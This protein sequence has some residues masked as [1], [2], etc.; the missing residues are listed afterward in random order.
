MVRIKNIEDLLAE[1]AVRKAATCYS[2]GVG[3]K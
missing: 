2:R 3:V 1:Q